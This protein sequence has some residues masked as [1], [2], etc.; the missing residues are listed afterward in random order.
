MRLPL[1][2]FALAAT[3]AAATA[4][5]IPLVNPSFEAQ[6]APPGQFVG[7]TN[8]ATTGWSVYNTIAPNTQRYFGI[9]N[10][11]STQLYLDP[12]PDGANVGV[13][14]LQ[15]TT[16]LAEAGLQQTTTAT[17]Q[18]NSR[19]TLRVDVGNMA[20]D[21]NPPQNQ[22][23][24]N[25]F[26]GYRID[27]LA[28]TTVIASDNN[29]LLPDEGRFLLSTVNFETGPTHAQLDQLLTIRL[30]NLNGPGIEVNFDRVRFDV[31][32]TPEP[33][34]VLAVTA[35]AGGVMRS[36]RRRR[37]SPPLRVQR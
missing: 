22:F 6:N 11:T 18:P 14:F 27:L 32:P 15:N 12:A 28:G 34:L 23:N 29:T 25:G 24:F 3:V 36:I 13:V 33:A 37:S 20:F 35:I 17:L 21:P 26:P 7:G 30:V 31:V 4:E 19:Y 10:P 1:S 9:V 8:F 16:G 5:P 2:L